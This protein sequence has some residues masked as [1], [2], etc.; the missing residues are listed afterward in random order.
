MSKNILYISYDGMTDPLG[1][2]Q[3]I[4]YLAGLTKEGYSFTIL[5]CEKPERYAAHKDTISTVLTAASI[6][7]QPILYTKKPPVLST[8][9]DYYQLK[10]K[11]QKLN[12]QLHFDLIHCRSYISSLLGLWMKRK[13]NIPFVFDMRGFWA[14]E[15]VDGGLWNLK[16]PVFKTVYNFFKK[17]ETEFLNESAGVVSL[18]EAGK[19][20]I[21]RWPGVKADA[22]KISIIPCCVDTESFNPDL[23]SPIKQQE[24][25]EQLHITETDFLLGYLGSIGTW[26]MLDEMLQFFAALKKSITHAKLLFVTQDNAAEIRQTATKY[27]INDTSIVITSAERNQVPLMISLFN[28]GLFFIKPAYSKTA[29]S[30]TKQGEIMAMGIPVVC[31]FG[32]GDTDKIIASYNSG[33]TVIGNKYDEVI[34]QIASGVKFDKQNIRAG[35]LDF[36]S[37]TNGVNKYSTIY[38][39]IINK[40]EAK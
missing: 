23:V 38:R 5:S 33:L 22:G 30:P 39:D 15:R 2:S 32:V 11:A 18:T 19:L 31:N 20:E 27:G 25:R 12:N 3:V 36:F 37:L 8:L 28:Y 1:Q 34:Q 35:A 10:R 29:S 6:S 17:K 24:L 16:N 26:Y 21:M 4:P 14:D 40:K 13:Y 7:W 9:Y